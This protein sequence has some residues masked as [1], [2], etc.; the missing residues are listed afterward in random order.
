MEAMI[1]NN[2][3]PPGKKP[4]KPNP[5]NKYKIIVRGI[6]IIMSKRKF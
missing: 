2:N 3:I 1:K 6:K 4:N 5:L